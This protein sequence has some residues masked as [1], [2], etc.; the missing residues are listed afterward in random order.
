MNSFVGIEIGGTKLQLYE[1]E[2]SGAVLDRHRFTV[3]P[4]DGAEGIR[5]RIADLL[6][7]LACARPP[8]AI[9]V[10][11][12]GPVDWQTGR[13][14]RSHQIEGWSGFHLSE[15]V[16]GL[17]GGVPVVVDNDANVA[18][19]GEAEAGAGQGKSPVFYMT[20][21]SGVGGGLVLNGRI[22]H[23]DSPGEAEI[24]HV[25]LDRSGVTV[26]A[27]CSGW[28]L[29]RKIRARAA[30]NPGGVMA[31]LTRNKKGG[32]ASVL[33]EALAKGDSAA[34]QLLVELVGN[35]AFALSH[36]AHLFHPQMIIVGGGLSGLGQPLIDGLRA[37]M[38][39]FLMEAFHPGPAIV[40]AELGEGA[41]PIGAICLARRAVQ[42]L[43]RT[44]AEV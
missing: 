36:V 8:M 30:E 25:R 12:G 42:S 26:E 24:G 40:P 5:R 37:E 3:D 4:T 7:K 19:L 41:V 10:G 29:D 35:L 16:S 17:A 38:P 39:R 1:A 44:P 33:L 18:A 28:A 13:I 15:W 2:A 11:F 9:G 27:E 6:P 43:R 14:C 23:G 22:Y 20:L 32:E 21:G 34:L 31:D